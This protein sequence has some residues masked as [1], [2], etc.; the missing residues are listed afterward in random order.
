MKETYRCSQCRFPKDRSEFH[1][2]LRPDRKRP[3]SSKCSDCRSDNYHATKYDQKCMAC[4]KPRALDSNGICNRCN[5]AAGKRQCRLCNEMR[6]RYFDF[7]ERRR[8]CRHCM[9]ARRTKITP[10]SAALAS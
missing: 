8:V 5:D 1:E 9:A 6:L 4:L 3:V 7:Y 2:E 10:P